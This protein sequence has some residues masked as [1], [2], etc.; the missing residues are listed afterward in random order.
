M[1]RLPKNSL[2]METTNTPQSNMLYCILV[3][4]A[5]KPFSEAFFKPFIMN[6]AKAK[7]TI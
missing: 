6:S 7:N 1:K 4:I 2:V 5:K 3:I